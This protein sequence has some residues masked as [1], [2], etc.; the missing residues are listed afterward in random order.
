[1]TS[2]R[3]SRWVGGQ[4]VSTFNEDTLMEQLSDQLLSHGDLSSAIRSLIQ[5]GARDSKGHKV[6]GIEELLQRLRSQRQDILNKYDLNSVVRDISKRLEGIIGMERRGIEDRLREVRERAQT[7]DSSVEIPQGELIQL[8]ERM[9]QR[10]RESLDSLLREPLEAIKELR[11]YEFMDGEAKEK[12][13]QLLEELQKRVI[14]SRFRDMS[15]HLQSMTPEELRELK[16]M[17]RS[18]DPMLDNRGQG[19]DPASQRFMER[20]GHLWGANPPSSLDDLM[21]GLQQ[22]AAQV[23]SLLNSMSQDMSGAQRPAG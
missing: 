21:E 7:G 5:R 8:M 23:R 6:A 20:Y 18:L 15:R 1:M 19:D 3:F 16:D 17:L 14:D 10:N 22:Q 11:D 12:F 2:Y 13:D 9:A 4:D